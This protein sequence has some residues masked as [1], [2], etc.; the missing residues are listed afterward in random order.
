MASVKL[1]PILEQIRGQIGDLVFKHIRDKAIVSRKPNREGVT[2]SEAQKAQNER[3][4]QAALY[5]KVILAEPEARA[6][7]EAAAEKDNKPLFSLAVADFL[8]APS[9]GEVDV[10]DY[11]GSVGDQLI[12]TARDDFEVVGVQVMLSDTDGNEIECGEAV[13]A[14][15]GDWVYT[16]TEAVATGTTVRIGVAAR[17]RP[18][19]IAEAVTETPV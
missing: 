5:G 10:S 15:G 12:I 18:G 4:R 9:I 2:L 6:L 1:N 14:A 16:A 7:Y 3:F 11:S 8:N 13:P 19:G 17:D